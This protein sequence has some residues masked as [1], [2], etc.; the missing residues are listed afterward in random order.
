MKKDDI[1]S[2]ELP[3]ERPCCMNLNLVERGLIGKFSGLW[4]SPN[5]IDGWVQRNWN[6]LVIEGI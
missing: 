5:H 6:P 1:P 4:P 2:V 3:I